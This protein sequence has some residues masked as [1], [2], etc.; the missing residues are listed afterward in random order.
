RYPVTS[1]LQAG[2]GFDLYMNRNDSYTLGVSQNTPWGQ[3]F[4]LQWDNTRTRTN[5]TYNLFNPTYQ[6]SFD[7]STSIPL[8]QGF[9]YKV[10]NRT[11][12]KAKLDRAEAGDQFQISMRNTLSQVEQ[13]YWNLVYAIRNLKVQEHALALAKEFQTETRKR[14]QAG[15][16]A[17]IEQISA[18]ASV[19]DREQ[20]I[21]TARSQ[22]QNSQ[23]ILKL[24][25]GITMNDPQWN[26]IFDPTSD[27]IEN[28]GDYNETH[29][30]EEAFK[31]RPELKQLEKELAKNK[32]DTHW[33]KNQMLPS[34]NLNAGVTYNGSAGD[35]YNPFTNEFVNQGFSDAWHQITGLDYKSWT[36]GIVFS[37][38]LFN[39]SAKFSYQNY[40]LA[41]NTTE[42][43]LEKQKQTIA[44]AVRLS[45][46]N[47]E[48]TEK[49]IAAAKLNVKL[50][51]EN[52]DAE[53]KKFENGLSTSY[54]VLSKQNDLITAQSTLLQALIDNQN[55]QAQLDQAVGTYLQQ[56]GV[57][58]T[59]R[60]GKKIQP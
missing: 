24:A 56:R 58:L 21:V 9:G 41:Q 60:K 31:L 17:P 52:L 29:L 1:V 27:P 11:V 7:L 50:Q 51:Q 26:Q 43:Q 23:D 39:R 47:L 45:L 32:L 13:S 19:A 12:L 57:E 53:K 35:Y 49:R 33:A 22:V 46:R 3:S 28:K 36:I 38:P 59:D 2:G 16:M 37:Y 54:I 40:R 18:D 20:N 4:N 14:I 30:I 5:S 25:M 10:A 15:V 42:I 44:N 55:A 34:L 48:T 6:S 8:L